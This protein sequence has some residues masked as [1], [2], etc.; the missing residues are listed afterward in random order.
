MI[1]RYTR[2]EM[3]AIWE[4][5]NK[6]SI[7]KEIEI[8]ACEA[9]AEL[10]KAGI[11]KEEAKWIRDHADF[12]VERIDEDR[13]GHQPRRHRLHHQHGRVHRCRRAGGRGEA[14]ALGA[15]RHDQQRLRRHG[16]FLPDHPGDRHHLGRR[17][18]AWRD[19]QAPR[20]RVPE[21]AVRGPHSRH[22][23]RADDLRHEVR[24]LGMGSEARSD[25][26]RAGTRGC[27]DGRHLGRG[28]HVF[29]HR[30][31]RRAVRMREAGPYA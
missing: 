11:T 25:A 5:Q 6:F 29:L 14:L 31:V 2:P 15:L 22:P 26:S 4:L 23:C 12:T 17:E 18:A 3:G 1:N 13:E 27:R 21:H 10:G 9:Q 8:L 20:L 28:G 16:A 19:V 7:W 24:Q 30:P